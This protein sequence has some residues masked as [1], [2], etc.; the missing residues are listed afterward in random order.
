M[1]ILEDSHAKKFLFVCIRL[2]KLF[3][4]LASRLA[5]PYRRLSSDGAAVRARWICDCDMIY[6]QHR[7]LSIICCAY[8]GLQSWHNPVKISNIFN[9][10]ARLC[11]DCN[12]DAIVRK[13]NLSWKGPFTLTYSISVLSLYSQ[14]H[15][16]HYKS[17][18]LLTLIPA[19]H[20]GNFLIIYTWC[21]FCIFSFSLPMWSF[22][23]YSGK[24]WLRAYY[25]S[26]NRDLVMRAWNYILSHI[27]M[28]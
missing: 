19:V 1:N 24:L 27:T 21:L 25:Y 10:L 6:L 13:E 4:T 18:S 3:F 12:H 17:P 16:P 7:S 11:R 2:I 14:S 28:A 23:F 20:Y 5:G 26:L 9:I 22:G 8:R 15:S